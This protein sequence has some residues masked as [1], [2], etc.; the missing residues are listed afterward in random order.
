MEMTEVDPLAL[1]AAAASQF[2]G[3]DSALAGVDGNDGKGFTHTGI[4]VA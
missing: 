4:A 2:D 3:D 1:A